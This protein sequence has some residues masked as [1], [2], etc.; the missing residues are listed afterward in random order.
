[1]KSNPLLPLIALLLLGYGGYTLYQ[2]GQLNLPGLPPRSSSN[3][4][5]T[6]ASTPPVNPPTTPPVTTPSTP[7][8]NTAS[9]EIEPALFVRPELK[10]LFDDYAKKDWANLLTSSDTY[11]RKNPTDA[12]A[13]LL[14][15]EAIIKLAKSDNYRIGLSAPL[16]GSLRQVGEAFLQGVYLA[17]KEVNDNGGFLRNQKGIKNKISVRVLNDAGDRTTAIKVASE[18]INDQYMWGVIGPYSSS[19]LL[20]SAP[21]YNAA[22]PGTPV[23]APAATN[24]KITNAG[25]MIYRV[26]PSDSTQGAALARLVKS[27]GA[28]SVAVLFDENDAYSL[29]LAQTFKAEAQNIALTTS[30][31]PFVLNSITQAKVG[32]FAVDAIFVSGYTAD[33]AAVARLEKPFN[34]PIYAGDGAYGQDLIAQGGQAVNGVIVT[35]FWHSTLTD[36]NSVQFTKR[37]QNLFGGGTPNANAM[38]AYDATRAMIEAMR[39]MRAKP[40]DGEGMRLALESLRTKPIDGITSPIRF[41][42]NGDMNDR[43]WVAIA[44]ENGKF[45]AVGYAK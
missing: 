19:T 6:P 29:G 37:F 28:K 13:G 14:R 34:K 9:L 18:M 17:V 3:P 39:R 12:M 1:M 43:P 22:S 2:R 24:P 16:T 21:I 10:V 30:D 42:V 33:V 15:E 4:P 11:R 26:A 7:P 8:A 27:R 5:S 25:R 23:I 31:I 44:V 36:K 40:E 32:N 20:A 41:D 35:S 38:Q 45:K